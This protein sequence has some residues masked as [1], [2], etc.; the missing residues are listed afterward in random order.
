M[1]IIIA[2]VAGLGLV[3]LAKAISTLW[4]RASIIVQ[5]AKEPPHIDQLDY[6]LEAVHEVKS[7][8]A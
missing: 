6:S 8:Q 7:E 1:P 5:K 3:G 2:I 4:Q